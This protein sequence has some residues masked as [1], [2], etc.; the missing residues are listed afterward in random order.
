M[1]LFIT[2]VTMK[3][4]PHANMELMQSTVVKDNYTYEP[5]FF[6][7]HIHYNFLCLWSLHGNYCEDNSIETCHKGDL[8]FIEDHTG[9]HFRVTPSIP[10]CN[11][12]S[13]QGQ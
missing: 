6:A 8:N 5:L 13:L 10:H 2:A 3:I 9:A 4:T 12:I 1:L 11:T 7:K